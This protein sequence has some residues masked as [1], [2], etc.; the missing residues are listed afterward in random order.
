M[1]I[2]NIRN[3]SIIAFLKKF[4]SVFFTLFFNIYVL[5]IVNDVG[6][7]I[8]LNLIRIIFEGLFGIF[9]SSIITNKNAKIIY[10]S[11][12]I[13]LIICILILI[14]FKEKI[15]NFIYIFIILY[16]LERVCYSV[17][18][19]MIVMGANN[20]KSMS[21]FLAN[22]NIINSIATILAPIFS[23]FIIEK[24]S[25][26]I[27][28][29][30]LG[31]EVVLVICIS[32]QIKNFYISNEKLKLK[33]FIVKCKNQLQLKNIYKCMFYRRISFQ[34]AITDLLPLLLFLKVNSEFSV[35]SYK[36]L[37]AIISIV[38]LSILKVINK[39]RI[40][41]K[42][43]IPFS[44]LIFFSSLFLVYNTSFITLMLYY[45]VI[46]SLGEILESE[47]CSAV[48]ES[49]NIDGLEKYKREHEIVFNIYMLVGQT[50][51]YLFA[52][53]MYIYFY[54]VNA[55]SISI[56]IMM[57][58]SIIACIYLQKTELF[59]FA[60]RFKNEE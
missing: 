37:F 60:K 26:N 38:S 3:I 58:F 39:K 17:P 55:I 31:I 42:F 46:N 20:Q 28:F 45:I 12:F 9:I 22:I 33:E 56:C 43:Y 48:Y 32:T 23:G 44:I 47:S 54:N 18:Y 24:F 14:I 5:K 27:L 40:K 59:L 30:L 15:C 51:S 19:E 8:M 10:N 35:G 49:I 50:I 29:I 7:I 36:S 41:K 13:Q 57:F 52:Y 21:N 1:D 16:A 25:Y 11:S 6:F 4:I 53:L 2:H 34:G